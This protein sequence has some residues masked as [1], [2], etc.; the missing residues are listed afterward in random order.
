M[1][2]ETGIRRVRRANV[3]TDRHLG[4]AQSRGHIGTLFGVQFD[5]RR[6]EIEIAV[7]AVLFKDADDLNFARKS[8]H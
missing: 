2:I 8:A 4:I 3:I 1:R 7:R 6:G 5:E